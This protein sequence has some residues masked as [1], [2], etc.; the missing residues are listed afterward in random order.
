MLHGWYTFLLL[1]IVFKAYFFGIGEYSL[2]VILIG[3]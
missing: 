3:M 1:P 2:Q